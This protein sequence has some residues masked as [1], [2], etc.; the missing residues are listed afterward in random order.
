MSGIRKVLRAGGDSAAVRTVSSGYLLE[1]DPEHV[2]A[3]RF[4]RLLDQAQRALGNDSASARDLFAQA[5]GLWRGPPFA[6]VPDSELVRRD[7]GRLEEL[8]TTAIEGLVEARLACGEHGVAITEIDAL[9][10]GNPL[11]ER[12][13]RLLMLALYRAGRHA[14]ALDAYRTA[15]AAL[16]E[17][18]LEP[19]PELRQLERLILQHDAALAPGV[20]TVAESGGRAGVPQLVER[21]P[22]RLPLPAQPLVG[23]GAEL[24]AVLGLFGDARARL[25]TLIGPGGA[26][27]TR[28]AMEVAHLVAGRHDRNWVWFAALAPLNDPSLILSEIRAPGTSTRSQARRSKRPSIPRWSTGNCCWCSTTSSM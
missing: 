16:D 8:R 1:V 17:I 21:V 14:D 19:S 24:D 2:D 7:A 22:P 28:L 26:G 27:K 23:R 12:P 4:E 10:A 6:D 15:C 13:R 18:G 25:V 5:L 11:R 20:S 3:R 9:V